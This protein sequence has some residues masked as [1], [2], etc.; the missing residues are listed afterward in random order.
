MFQLA[1]KVISPQSCQPFMHM[2]RKK[3]EY[4]RRE[5]NL[6]H[7]FIHNLHYIGDS[8]WWTEEKLVDDESEGVD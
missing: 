5:V 6:G 1:T 4:P 3:K 7:L 2:Q 8:R